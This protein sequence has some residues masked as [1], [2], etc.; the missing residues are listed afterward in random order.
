M[1][2]PVDIDGVL[3]ANFPDE[4]APLVPVLKRLNSTGSDVQAL[5]DAAVVTAMAGV[6]IA[7]Q[8]EA[9]AGIQNTKMMTALRT[10]QAI[11]AQVPALVTAGAP[12][13]VV[14]SQVEAEAGADN[15]KMMTALRAAQAIAALTPAQNVLVASVTV[16]SADLL[17]L[18]AN[19]KVIIA[20]PAA[21]S[22]H[23]LIAAVII[24]D[25]G[26]V[27]YTIGTAGNLTLNYRPDGSG[28]T[29]SVG[30]ASTGFLDSAT[31]LVRQVQLV[32]TNVEPVV[33]AN[34]AIVLKVATASPTLGNGEL[35]V[36]ALYRTIASGL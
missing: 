7:S 14:A 19:P 36:I 16:S 6:S 2:F 18:F 30:L 23:M 29:L 13:E 4:W 8:A 27:A 12:A 1:P 9:E 28:D 34:G 22:F 5:V 10:K 3:I 21:G 32:A 24:Y 20:A 31:D 33:G 25:A 17:D 35:R 11:T 26:G 15:T